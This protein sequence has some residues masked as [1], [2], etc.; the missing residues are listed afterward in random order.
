MNS[1]TLTI[2]YDDNLNDVIDN[3]NGVLAKIG[4][5]FQDDGL[6]HD[7]FCIYTL[8]P[9]V[10]TAIVHNVPDFITK[11]AEAAGKPDGEATARKYLLGYAHGKHGHPPSDVMDD[12]YMKGYEAG[13]ND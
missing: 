12:D 3:V 11:A 10:L 9:I 2:S 8:M 1:N 13:L 7:G 5:I 6:E 4:L